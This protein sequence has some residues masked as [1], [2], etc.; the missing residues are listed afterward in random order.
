MHFH[1]YSNDL[2]LIECPTHHFSF[3]ETVA[4]NMHGYS[5]RQVRDSK[6]ARDLMTAIACP[7]MRE[8]KSL[9]QTN[10]L[11]NCPVT[12]EDVD[13]AVAIFGHDIPNL[14]GKVV[15][16]RPDVVKNEVIH[17]P[18]YVLDKNKLITMS[19]DICF[20]NTLPFLGTLSQVK[21]GTIQ[22]MADRKKKSK[23]SGLTTVCKFYGARGFT[24]KVIQADNEF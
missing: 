12:L 19:T 22:H 9:I 23:L 18:R 3:V 5:K 6:R 1:C 14:K 15:R 2:H 24:V 10:M 17:V 20:V 13:R 21:F 4:E 7:S 16:K 11:M 8:F